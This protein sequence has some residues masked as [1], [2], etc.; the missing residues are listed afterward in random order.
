[1]TEEI[2]DFLQEFYTLQQKVMSALFNKGGKYAYSE[3]EVVAKVLDGNIRV[4]HIVIQASETDEDYA[5]KQKKANETLARIEGGED[6]ETV[7]AEVGEDPGMNTYPDGYVFNES[8]VL[9]DSPTSTPFD[10]NFTAE[11]FKLAVNQ[12]S[13]IVTSSSGLHII[14]RLPLDEAFVKE[15]ID[16]YY[17]AFSSE[18]FQAKVDEIVHALDVKTTDAYNNLDVSTFIDTASSA[19][20][21]TPGTTTGGTAGGSTGGTAGGSTGSSATAG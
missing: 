16:D 20:S 13:G 21:A 5:E 19:S 14:K 7:L 1:M 4:R 12:V 11:S 18:A 15:H 2:Y 8:G 17:S 9:V 3:D 10:A 6:F